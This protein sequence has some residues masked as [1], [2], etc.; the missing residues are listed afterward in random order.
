MLLCL[1]DTVVSIDKVLYS[2]IHR[3]VRVR[4]TVLNLAESLVSH[5]LRVKVSEVHG[6]AICGGLFYEVLC[7][8]FSEALRTKTKEII[9]LYTESD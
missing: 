6:S 3:A 5:R 8:F 2:P 9:I 1:F 7:T 4:P